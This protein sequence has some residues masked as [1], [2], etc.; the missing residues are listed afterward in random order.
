MNK[1]SLEKNLENSSKLDKSTQIEVWL[2]RLFLVLI[3]ISI[4]FLILEYLSRRYLVTGSQFEQEFPVWVGRAPKPYVMFGGMPGAYIAENVYLNKLGYKGPA[5]ELVGNDQ[6]K[7][8]FRIFIL[9][10]STIFNGDPPIPTLLE[11]KFK[12]QGYKNVRVYN[13][14]VVS[15]VSSQELVRVLMEVLDYRP[16]I[17]IMYNG[18]NDFGEPLAWDPRPGYPF[19]FI[20]YENNPILESNIEKYKFW[21]LLLYGSN[22]LRFFLGNYFVSQFIDLNEMRKKVNYQTPA[23]EDEIINVYVNNFKKASK[24][25][26]AYH[27]KF[28][29]IYQPNANYIKKKSSDDYWERMRTKLQAKISGLKQ[30]EKFDFYDYSNIYSDIS[31]KVFVDSVHT[32]QKFKNIVSNRIFKD[33][34][35]LVPLKFKK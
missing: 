23:W 29:G 13:F 12:E 9:G 30:I 8:E 4:C 32:E 16:D 15:S 22:F 3:S 17:T 24:I 10:G 19:N 20:V 11:Q 14:G 6:V 25:L 1:K 35:N 26:I 34:K 33:I 28:V 27:S 2:G 18:F 7:K 31:E 21:S 5:P